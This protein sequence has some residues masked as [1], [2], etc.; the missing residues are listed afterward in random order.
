ANGAEV[1][2]AM[3]KGVSQIAGAFKAALPDLMSQNNIAN[4]PTENSSNI[5]GSGGG[6]CG[7][8][9][10]AAAAVCGV[11]PLPPIAGMADVTGQK[12]R[13]EQMATVLT[14]KIKDI[15]GAIASPPP[16]DDEESKNM[17]TQNHH[18]IPHN[19]SKFAHHKHPLVKQAEMNL[20]TEKSNLIRLLNHSGPHSKSYHRLVQD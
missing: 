20:K 7:G 5:S 10:A 17:R 2:A 12:E 13:N 3:G 19:N 14:E 4:T 1:R 15:A 9:F 8:I 6:G 16:P 11:I 18:M